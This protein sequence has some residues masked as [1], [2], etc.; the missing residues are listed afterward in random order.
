M[1]RKELDEIRTLRSLAT[2]QPNPF[3]AGLEGKS[4]LDIA[5]VINREDQKVAV[6]VESA[7]PQIARAID[8]IAEAL[9]TGGRLI[10]VGA[11]TSA[12]IAALDAVECPPTYNTDPRTVQ[13]VVAGGTKALASA[14]ESNEDSRAL[15]VRE[16][17][18]KRP[19]KSDV[20]VGI[21]ASGRTPFT[22]AAIEWARRAGAKTVAIT[23][24]PDTP[25]ERA[26][27]LAIVV[28]T[29]PE[30]VGGSTRM[31]A[32]TAQKMV[33]NMLSTGAMVRLGFVYGNLMVNLHHGN[34]KLIDRSIRILQ[35][36]LALPRGQA[37]QM[38]RAAH[39]DVPAAIVMAKARVSRE[40]AQDALKA[41]RG[42]VR[43]AIRRAALSKERS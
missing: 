25:L 32:G 14:V 7:L 8:W 22:V 42:H 28:E 1:R 21:A 6:A 15:G 37:K 18:K 3:S 10:Y 33:L 12:R 16:M 17:R 35:Q 43:N 29:G 41:A 4:A 31:K 39:N 34:T 38:L 40:Q 26:A 19:E 2:E 20:I 27:Q 5:R 30:V 23:S 24:N 36:S 9:S 13:F 11:G